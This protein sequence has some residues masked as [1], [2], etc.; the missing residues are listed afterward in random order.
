MEDKNKLYRFIK[1]NRIKYFRVANFVNNECPELPNKVRKQHIEIWANSK[2]VPRE[3]CVIKALAKFCK[4]EPKQFLQ[5]LY[6][7]QKMKKGEVYEQ[8]QINFTN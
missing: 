5:D 3:Q 1:E 4:T 7:Y 8:R 6:F 2:A